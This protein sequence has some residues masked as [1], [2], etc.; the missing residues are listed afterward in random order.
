MNVKRI[1]LIQRIIL[2]LFVIVG[3]LYICSSLFYSKEGF[4]CNTR[5]DMQS[6][7]KTYLCDNKIEAE[8]TL[9]NG[10][11]ADLTA[12]DICY[13]IG[14]DSNLP[15]QYVCYDRP[16]PRIF[17]DSTTSYR[18]YDNLGDNDISPIIEEQTN[19]TYCNSYINIFN[20]FE[21]AYKNT[22]KFQSSINDIN[23]SSIRSIV[24]YLSN[25]S[26]MYCSRADANINICNI[27][28]NGITD[29]ITMRDDASPNT[30]N[31]ISTNV[32]HTLVAMKQYI[33]HDLVPMYIDSGCINNSNMNALR[34]KQI[35]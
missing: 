12:F 17:D 34:A 11:P 16:G 33:Y 18:P 32:G 2:F 3:L 15:K 19:I 9:L 14:T 24:Y 6:G 35:F 13:N 20:S 31:A 10:I 23:I 30:I 1:R 8:D 21:N 25:T 5:D 29:F 26:T 4:A 7:T 28:S 22:M 27:L